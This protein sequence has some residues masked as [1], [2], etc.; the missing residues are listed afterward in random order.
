MSKQHY[1]D[2]ANETLEILRVGEYR[3][4]DVAVSLQTDL[5]NCR[6]LTQL[7]AADLHMQYL[8]HHTFASTTIEVVQEST[9]QSAERLTR[10]TTDGRNVGILNFASAKNPGGGWLRGT[11]TQEE[12]L[13]RSSGLYH[14]LTK[15]QKEFYDH[16]R[17]VED[18][19]YSDALIMSPM[20]PVFRNHYD[21]LL[22]RPYKIN[23]VT[24]A[25]PNLRALREQGRTTSVFHVLQ[26]RI[27]RILEAFT[28]IDSNTLVLGAWGCGVFDNDPVDVARIFR[29]CLC[30]NGPYHHHFAH[31]CFSIVDDGPNLRAFRQAFKES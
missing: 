7:W 29:Y 27:Y 12:T 19:I 15:Y 13:A 3:V 9:L 22:V 21:V 26:Q 31:V 17:V 6:S 16:H 4:G 24:C 5:Q 8:P 23:I 25:A 14:S 11:T 30:D 2:L 1:I 20:C 28:F 10:T 18:A